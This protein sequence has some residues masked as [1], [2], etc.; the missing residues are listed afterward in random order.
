MV[1]AL[2]IRAVVVVLA[3]VMVRDEAWAAGDKVL[4]RPAN[5]SVLVAVQRLL[6][7]QA[8]PVVLYPA[9]SAANRC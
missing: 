1:R 2:G 3:K 9:R 8:F 7:R 6:T 5:V 4:V